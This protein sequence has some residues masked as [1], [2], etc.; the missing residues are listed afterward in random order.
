VQIAEAALWMKAAE[1]AFDYKGVPTNLVAATASHL[2]GEAWEAFLAGFESEPSVARVLRKF[3]QTMEHIDEI[4]SLARLDEDLREI[5]QEEHATWERQV[6]QKKETNYLFEELNEDALS[7]QLPFQEISD[8]EF[9]DRLFDRALGGIDDFTKRA[10]EAGKFEDQMLGSETHAGFRLLDL[11]SRRYDVV[12]AN[13]PYMGS[14]NM[15]PALK[16]YVERN[17]KPGKRD[18]YA[19]FILRNLELAGDGGRVAM[20]TQQSWMFLRSFA[21][22]RAV[23]NE[24]LDK[25]A[26]DE[27]RG[28]LRDATV[29]TLTHL[30]PN[31]FGE[32][33][34]EVVNTVLFVL[35]NAKPPTEH[36]L[37]AFRLRGSASRPW[38]RKTSPFKV[39][40]SRLLPRSASSLA[41]DT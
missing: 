19:A 1:R 26:A 25:L 39:S 7:G 16:N 23:E 35:A 34:G 11:L 27:P 5:I 41:V 12:A 18:L 40:H 22:L 28:L 15:G 36:R 8:E 37:T 10:R 20:V 24:M 30:G 17:F 32:I 3:A 9:G 13:P 4:G 29:E 38:D 2:K 21:D 14:K 31:A 33:S 6:S